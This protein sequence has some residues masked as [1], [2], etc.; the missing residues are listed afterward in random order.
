MKPERNKNKNMNN[1]QMSREAAKR[2][3]ENGMSADEA[4][5]EMIRMMGFRLV[6][7]RIPRETRAA[8]MAAVKKGKLGRLK[9]EGMRPEVFFHP[10]SIWK[11]MEARD[12]VFNAGVRAVRAC[13]C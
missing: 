10:N 1:E 13:C 12:K 4:N 2:M 9:K 6:E 8:L 7:N 3:M 5:V 11:A